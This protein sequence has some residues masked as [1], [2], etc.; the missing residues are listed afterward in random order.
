MR[1]GNLRL[2]LSVAMGLCLLLPL[3]VVAQDETDADT[4]SGVLV[5]ELEGLA[6]HRSEDLVGP[7][8]EAALA[9]ADFDAWNK[10]VEGAG[11]GFDD[12]EYTFQS[13][14]DPTTLPQLGSVGTVRVAGAQ[15]DALRAAVVGDIVDQVTGLGLSEPTVE[16]TTIGDKDVTI[17][18]LP[19]EFGFRSDAT[20]YVQGDT[21]WV[22]ILDDERLPVALGQLP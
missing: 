1:I 13:V 15:P 14:F 9:G 12:L 21:A 5:P 7:Q 10:L 4:S 19:D 17:V 22:L 6:W 11:G 8:M 3:A 16:E 18:A 2:A 20:V